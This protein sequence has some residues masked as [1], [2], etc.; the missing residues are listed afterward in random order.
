MREYLKKLRESNGYTMQYVA[1]RIGISKQY[2]QRIE[3]GDRQQNMDITL[4][5]KL[6]EI[7]GVTIE[8]IIK[9]EKELSLARESAKLQT[10]SDSN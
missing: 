9:N 4:A 5:V 1:D 8:N 6:S 7:F 10:A 3:V 2:Y